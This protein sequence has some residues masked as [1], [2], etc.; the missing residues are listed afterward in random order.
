MIDHG[1]SRAEVMGYTLD[2]ARFY[3]D[4]IAR[5][6]RSNLRDMAIAARVAQFDRSSWKQ[7]IDSFEK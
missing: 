7:F 3:G 2:Q 6:E 4:A 5:K 1:H